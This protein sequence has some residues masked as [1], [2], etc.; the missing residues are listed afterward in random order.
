MQNL[1]SKIITRFPHILYYGNQSK[2]DFHT[3]E[4]LNWLNKELNKKNHIVIIRNKEI[5][6]LPVKITQ[7]GVKY[8]IIERLDNEK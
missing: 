1:P 2:I 7:K 6:N 4:D 5:K 8:S 3:E